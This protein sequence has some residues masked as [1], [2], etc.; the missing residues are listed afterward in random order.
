MYGKSKMA[1][2]KVCPFTVF[3]EA[4]KRPLAGL[5]V[6]CRQGELMKI[7]HALNATAVLASTLNGW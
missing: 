2:L 7:V 5:E 6:H 4:W 1:Q 3:S